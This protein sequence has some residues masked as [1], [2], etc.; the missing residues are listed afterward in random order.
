MRYVNA[1]NVDVG[2]IANL[3]QVRQ[4]GNLP[5]VSER[6]REDSAKREN[7]LAASPPR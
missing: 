5:H 6:H 7:P 1:A 2:Q 4:V 3:P